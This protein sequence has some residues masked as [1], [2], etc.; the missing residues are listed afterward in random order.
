M[1]QGGGHSK[2]QG[3]QVG[4]CWAKAGS[5][6]K[7]RVEG[8]SSQQVCQRSGRGKKRKDKHWTV[9]GQAKSPAGKEEAM[10]RRRGWEAGS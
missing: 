6:V 9:E 1:H 10:E 2:D 3:L 7:Y 5:E 8:L 4:K